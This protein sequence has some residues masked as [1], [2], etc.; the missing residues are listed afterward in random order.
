[1]SLY[2][3]SDEI[4]RSWEII[5]PFIAASEADRG[6]EPEIYPVGSEGPKS[7]AELLAREG[8]EWMRLP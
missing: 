4:E 7:A 5:D 6:V 8:R 1:A 3:R 2:M